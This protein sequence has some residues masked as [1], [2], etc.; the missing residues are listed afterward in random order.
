MS[1]RERCESQP[2]T[3]SLLGSVP[4]LGQDQVLKKFGVQCQTCQAG[5]LR[6]TSL[7]S[8]L[9]LDERVSQYEDYNTHPQHSRPSV[10][11]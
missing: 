3:R 6:G 11:A 1:L 5:S 8:Q 10:H 4:F 7:P 2:R 9:T